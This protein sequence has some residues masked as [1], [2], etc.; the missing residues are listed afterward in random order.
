MSLVANDLIIKAMRVVNSPLRTASSVMGSSIGNGISGFSLSSLLEM[1]AAF[2]EI[3]CGE[4]FSCYVHI[5]NGTDHPMTDVKIRVAIKSGPSD[6]PQQAELLPQ[7][8]LGPFAGGNS[9][10][11]VVHHSLSDTGNHLVECIV[12]YIDREGQLQKT[13]KSWPFEVQ[14][15]MKLESTVAQVGRASLVQLAITNQMSKAV[16][17]E[18]LLFDHSPSYELQDLNPPSRGVL[19]L[20][21]QAEL[22]QCFKLTPGRSLAPEK[23]PGYLGCLRMQYRGPMGSLG[24]L[25]LP[26]VRLP[27]H[28]LPQEHAGPTGVEVTLAGLPEGT[29]AVGVPRAV[30]LLVCNRTANSRKLSLELH[31]NQ[32]VGV[33]LNGVSGQFLGEVAPDGQA[34]VVLDLLPMVPGV[35]KLGGVHVVDVESFQRSEFQNIGEILVSR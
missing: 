33:L 21:P 16:C 23:D 10:D 11:F 30:T 1:P 3:Y 6:Q 31:S 18:E 14:A 12:T 27:R 17:L 24:Q 2:G 15:P 32:M 19:V 13:K 5:S 29:F 28:L 9:R 34:E 4:K 22:Q 7:M 26:A 35:Q 25:R 20:E 8:S